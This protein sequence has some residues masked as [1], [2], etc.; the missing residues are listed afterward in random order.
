MPRNL[1]HRIEVMVPVE[2]VRQREELVAAFETLLADN[3]AAW[4]LRPDGGW[5]RTRPVKDERARSA[6]ATEM[7]RA[8]RRASHRRTRQ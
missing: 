2:D 5:D 4:R 7:R 8:R 3:T 1:D 6:Q